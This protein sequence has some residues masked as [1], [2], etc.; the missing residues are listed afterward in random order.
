[1]LVS[2]KQQLVV[3][4]LIVLYNEVTDGDGILDRV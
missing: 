4:L 3:N 1:M 2:C